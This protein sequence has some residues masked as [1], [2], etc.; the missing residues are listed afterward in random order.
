MRLV[1]VGL[2][3]LWLPLGSVAAADEAQKNLTLNDLVEKAKALDG[4]EVTVTGEAIGDVMVRGDHGW[5]NI[6]DG[7]NAIGV[8]A[9]ADLLGRI[10]HAGQYGL[11][12]DRVR[13]V[14]IFHRMD[15]QHGGDIDIRARTL[16]VIESGG[17]V[18]HPVS[19]VRL[20]WAAV[21]GALGAVTGGLSWRRIRPSG[22]GR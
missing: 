17:P 19:P 13:V 7:T 20:F 18:P 1:V 21:A 22:E 11:N 9:P 10:Q 8:W 15:R 4:M 12:G 14:G 3:A 5:V 2:V 16:E 6:S